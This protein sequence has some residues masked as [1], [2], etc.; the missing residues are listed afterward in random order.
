MWLRVFLI[1][2]HLDDP[3]RSTSKKED[4][5]AFLARTQAQRQARQHNKQM[6]LAA[7]RIQACFR[8]RRCVNL[9]RSL[10]REDFDQICSSPCFQWGHVSS[11]VRKINFICKQR[12]IS[13]LLP[14]DVKRFLIAISLL[15]GCF[16]NVGGENSY[17]SLGI[18]S[19]LRLFE[20]QMRRVTSTV[21][22]LLGST[23]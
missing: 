23:R 7:V 1:D 8:S 10:A 15:H 6:D 5:D 14:Q 11:V 21:V 16:E 3:C 19:H 9:A 17:V 22:K 18:S 2:L 20:L 12:S 4:R 13:G